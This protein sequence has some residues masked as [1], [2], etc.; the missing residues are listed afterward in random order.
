MEGT[1][2]TDKSPSPGGTG[3]DGASEGSTDPANRSMAMAS[4]SSSPG[5][6]SAN[7]T[8]ATATASRLGDDLSN[9]HC[10]PVI[11]AEGSGWARTEIALDPWCV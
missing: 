11:G 6:G 7:G 5:N 8:S 4:K 10:L 1:V 3:A 2:Y 9:V